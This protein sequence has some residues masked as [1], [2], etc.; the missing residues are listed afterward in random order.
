MSCRD[1]KC[2]HLFDFLQVYFWMWLWWLMYKLI[3]FWYFQGVF[4]KGCQGGDW[5]LGSFLVGNSSVV[6]SGTPSYRNN[7]DNWHHTGCARWRNYDNIDNIRFVAIIVVVTSVDKL[8]NMV[9]TF[10]SKTLILRE[11]SCWK[12]FKTADLGN[13]QRICFYRTQVRS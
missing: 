6:M 13:A 7:I 12:W 5:G 4:Y 3:P 9:P 8:L 10:M 1:T 2:R 11:F